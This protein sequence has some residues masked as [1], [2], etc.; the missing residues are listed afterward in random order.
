MEQTALKNLEDKLEQ[1]LKKYQ[2]LQKENKQLKFSLSETQTALAKSQ[3]ACEALQLK[4]EAGIIAATKT[5]DEHQQQLL[6]T[7]IDHYLKEI[8]KCLTLLEA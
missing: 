7:R 3:K 2:L 8:N 1:L 6:E 5:M 4:L